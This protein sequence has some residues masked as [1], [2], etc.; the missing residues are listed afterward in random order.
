MVV[1]DCRHLPHL[2]EVWRRR[3]PLLLAEV[4]LPLL[5]AEVRLHHHLPHHPGAENGI[6]GNATARVVVSG[7]A[8]GL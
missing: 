2:G 7:L 8:R 1:E 5:L 6:I 3:P 4:R